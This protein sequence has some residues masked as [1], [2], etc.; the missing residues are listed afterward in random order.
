MFLKVPEGFQRKKI[1]SCAETKLVPYVPCSTGPAA[2]S[3]VL[4]N[5]CVATLCQSKYLLLKFYFSGSLATPGSSAC[6]LLQV[7]KG[8][9]HIYSF[10]ELKHMFGL[11]NS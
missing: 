11:Q 3:C 5:I 2:C 10:T 7:T 9:A 6:P 4:L 1:S 8:F